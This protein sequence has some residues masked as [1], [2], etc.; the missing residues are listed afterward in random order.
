M[1]TKV[2]MLAAHHELIELAEGLPDHVVTSMDVN[3]MYECVRQGGLD[4]LMTAGTGSVPDIVV[5]GDAIHVAEAL[6][7]AEAIDTSSLRVAVALVAEP[8]TDLA[9]RAMR[10]GVRDVVPPSIDLDELKVVLHR[11]ET[12]AAEMA[13]E[14]PRP[15]TSSQVIVVTSPRGGVGRS[16]VATTLAVELARTTEGGTVLIDLDLQFGDVSSLLDLTPMYTIGDAWDASGH[17]DSLI[18]KT[19]LCKHESGLQVLCSAD[20]PTMA[21]RATSEQVAGLVQQL[22]S[23]FSHVVIDTAAGLDDAALGAIGEATDLVV[24]SSTDVVCAK[25][26]RK[27]MAMID[28]L[29]TG[30]AARHLVVNAVARRSASDVRRVEAATG[31][32]AGVLIPRSA[33]LRRAGNL[34]RA[35]SPSLLGAPVSRSFGQLAALL[36]GSADLRVVN[37]HKGVAMT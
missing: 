21:D 18:L 33:R 17:T 11:M 2:L 5:L 30:R 28:R 1:S 26:L 20:S 31:V 23:Q 3:Q 34:G 35:T 10:V 37:K 7:V 27:Q 13:V 8:E 36:V 14:V 15:S 25:S 29:S 22:S 4:L 32:P 19:L 24:V 16:T 9:I 6:T 12:R